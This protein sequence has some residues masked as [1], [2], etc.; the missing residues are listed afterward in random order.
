MAAGHVTSWQVC[1]VCS[2]GKFESRM[3]SVCPQLSSLRL[4]LQNVDRKARTAQRLNAAKAKNNAM[5]D[6]EVGRVGTFISRCFGKLKH[7]TRN[8]RPHLFSL[9]GT[10]VFC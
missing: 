5:D 10:L 9:C 8:F 6:E 3:V 7:V 4:C 1:F 2:C